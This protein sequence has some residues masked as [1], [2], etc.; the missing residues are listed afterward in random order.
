MRKHVMTLIAA[1]A[2]T[3]G[4]AV[5]TAPSAL[6][7]APDAAGG[8]ARAAAARAPQPAAN[9]NR[10]VR[11][12]PATPA[13]ANVIYS[14]GCSGT[15]L[16]IDCTITEP[17]VTQ[18]ETTYPFS[19]L[20]GDHVTVTAGGCVQTGGHGLTW[21]RY[22]DP[23]SDNDLYHGLITVPGATAD[24]A[25]LVNVVGR[26]YVV[27]GRGGSLK[28]GYEDDGYSDNGYTAHDNGTGNQC[29]NSVNAYVRIVVS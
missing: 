5:S 16:P 23:A 4:A 13:A 9:V 10:N 2:L 20:P 8:T 15:T 26:P 14:P 3:A 1:V 7:A 29:L 12:V 18:R 22:V 17:V 19:F 24:L 28:L 6:A 21:K 25:R 11:R 27:G